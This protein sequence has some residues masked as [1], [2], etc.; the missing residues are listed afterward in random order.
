MKVFL[1]FFVDLTTEIL[2][3]LLNPLVSQIEHVQIHQDEYEHAMNHFLI[4]CLGH[5]ASSSRTI[6]NASQNQVLKQLN[7]S[8]TTMTRSPNPR[9]R[10][11]C[12]G[13]ISTLYSPLSCGEDMLTVF[14]ETIPCL[15]ELLEDED[16]QV[17]A[18][19]RKVCGEIQVVL[20]EDLEPFFNAH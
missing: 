12:L 6:T 19:T 3:N 10:L 4:P 7:R 13:L 11:T 17:E 1:I 8:V 16:E 5:L 14:P 15:A 2:L 9:I 20:G 18:L